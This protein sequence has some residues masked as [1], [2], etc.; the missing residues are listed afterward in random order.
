MGTHTSH[1]LALICI[2][3]M[4]GPSLYVAM[5]HTHAHTQDIKRECLHNIIKFKSCVR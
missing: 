2:V 1:I 5:I 4:H 3:G